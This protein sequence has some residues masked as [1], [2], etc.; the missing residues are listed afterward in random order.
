MLVKVLDVY[1]LVANVF[2]QI[3]LFVKCSSRK[4]KSV[5]SL[6]AGT[7]AGWPSIHSCSY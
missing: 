1:A 7:Q 4:L 5:K 6:V 3:G 2:F